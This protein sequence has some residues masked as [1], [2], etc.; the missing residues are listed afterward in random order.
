MKSSEIVLFSLNIQLLCKYIDQDNVTL[1][2]ERLKMAKM[3]HWWADKQ[4]ICEDF[5]RVNSDNEVFF[6]IEST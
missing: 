3:N 4:Y 6:H 5:Q 2:S 1:P